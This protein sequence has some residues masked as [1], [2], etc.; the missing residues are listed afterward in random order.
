MS[1]IRSLLR[2][3]A[4]TILYSSPAVAAPEFRTIDGS[5]NNLANLTWGMAGTDLMRVAPETYLAPYGGTGTR[6]SA[7]EVSNALAAQ[8]P[9][10]MPSSAGISNMF[11][12]WGQFLDH[13]ISI[14]PIAGGDPMSIPVPAGDPWFDP[15][16]TGSMSLRTT[17][18]VPSSVGADGSRAH[19]NAITS[20]IDASMVYGSDAATAS[21]LRTNDGT[22]KM[23]V[24]EGQLPPMNE[25][26]MF[27]TGDTRANE[28]IALLSMHTLFVRE[29]NR[30]AD[31]L[32]ALNPHWD[33]ERIYQEARRIV[34]A[35]IQAITYN[36]WLPVVLGEGAMSPYK[37]Y[38]A[39]VDPSVTQEFSAIGFRFGHTTLP[40]VIAR[41]NADGTPVAG[42]NLMLK[43]AFFNPS[44][45][46]QEGG[47]DPVLRGLAAT[48]ASEIDPMIVDAVRNFLVL[49][50]VHPVMLDL[51]ALNIERARDRGIADY[52]SV[53]AAYG[54]APIT[55]FDQLSSDPLVNA[56]FKAVYGDVNNIDAW[57][58][59]LAEDPHVLADGTT[60]LVGELMHTLI[61]DQFTRLRDGDRF[62]FEA[63]MDSESLA[64]LSGL[65]LAD[66]VKWNTGVDWLHDSMFVLADRVAGAVSAPAPLSLVLL[67]LACLAWRARKTRA[68]H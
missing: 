45:L 32:G 49:N 18:A 66:V 14:T 12:A 17:R 24:S 27:M 51:A 22:G 6:A 43:D 40:D 62:W 54:L 41:L 23:R 33:G 30:L 42:G 52:N 8:G 46:Q 2:V 48:A 60:A 68:A 19:P 56:A 35:E 37:G 10:T 16:G 15:A 5:G 63:A 29:H 58:A 11:W 65:R 20:W 26:G 55:S 67:G 25:M 53:R 47:L 21:K 1:H 28:N 59:A 44:L 61:T 64:W 39:H 50:P 34:G 7:R 13:D 3:I 38:D 57:I 31:A 9:R 4:V 36:E